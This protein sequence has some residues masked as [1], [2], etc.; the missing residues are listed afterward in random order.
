MQL[1]NIGEPD[2][3]DEH[4]ISIT[5]DHRFYDSFLRG[6]YYG[7]PQEEQDYLGFGSYYNIIWK[8]VTQRPVPLE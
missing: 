6:D 4:D 2:I 5:I 3:A 1:Y 7:I 8:K